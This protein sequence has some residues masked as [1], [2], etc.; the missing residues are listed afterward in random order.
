M[1][2]VETENTVKVILRTRPTQHF[3][4]NNIRI[5]LPDNNIS[6]FI[7]RNQKEGII[8]NQKEQWSFHF[9]KILHNVP[10]EEVFEYTMNDIIKSS[11]QGYNGTVFAYGQTGSGK[12]FTISGAPNNFTYRG[13]IPRSI[14]RL[15][16][17][18]SNKP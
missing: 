14:T 17:E 13:I 4:T 5:N 7:P 16:N 2:T 11:V 3:A 15:F 12:T 6:I 8:N 9:D 1:A 18:I 10:Q